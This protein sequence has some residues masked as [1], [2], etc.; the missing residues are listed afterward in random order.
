LVNTVCLLPCMCCSWYLHLFGPLCWNSEGCSVDNFQVIFLQLIWLDMR[1]SSK[2]YVLIMLKYDNWIWFSKI[3]D[4]FSNRLNWSSSVKFSIDWY[5]IKWFWN[6]LSVSLEVIVQRLH[7]SAWTSISSHYVS[8]L[9]VPNW[10]TESPWVQG[11]GSYM[12]HYSGI[13][14][15]LNGFIFWKQSSGLV[16]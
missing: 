16:W 12:F 10:M 14:F 11:T 4:S 9:Q 15:P 2:F 7:M 8:R 1:L 13:W 5:S 6:D 3:S